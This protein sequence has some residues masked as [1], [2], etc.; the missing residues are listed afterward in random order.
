MVLTQ[1]LV[2]TLPVVGAVVELL[3][4]KPLSPYGELSSSPLCTRVFKCSLVLR[5]CQIGAF[6]VS[7]YFVFCFAISAFRKEASPWFHNSG[8]F[9][10]NFIL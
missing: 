5:P 1:S 10:I 7:K 6:R 8:I 3:A 2:R 4:W 9:Y